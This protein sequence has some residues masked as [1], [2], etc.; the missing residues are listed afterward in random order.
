MAK[1]DLVAQAD[2]QGQRRVIELSKLLSQCVWQEGKRLSLDG[3]AEPGHQFVAVGFRRGS[4]KQA[5]TTGE[6]V[7]PTA[8]G[9]PA[10]EALED[11]L[12]N[13]RLAEKF[14]IVKQREHRSAIIF[15]MAFQHP[16]ALQRDER[17]IEIIGALQ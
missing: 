15:R 17:I 4:R 8:G 7:L 6:V 3:F 14:L 16:P 9:E 13:H 5:G 12:F 1:R 11:M 2:A 10:H